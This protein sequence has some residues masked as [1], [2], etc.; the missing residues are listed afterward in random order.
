V[1]PPPGS[2]AP[3]AHESQSNLDDLYAS[4]ADEAGAIEGGGTIIGFGMYKGNPFQFLLTPL[5]TGYGNWLLSPEGRRKTA[6]IP[7]AS[8]LRGWLLAREATSNA[9]PVD[10]GASHQQL[11]LLQDRSPSQRGS[12][13]SGSQ[14][15]SQLGIDCSGSG[16]M[17]LHASIVDVEQ[18]RNTHQPSGGASHPQVSI[19]GSVA[20]PSV[21]GSECVSPTIGVLPTPGNISVSA[22]FGAPPSARPLPPSGPWSPPALEPR[23]GSSGNE[24]ARF[25][26]A[27]SARTVRVP[28]SAGSVEC[29]VGN[30]SMPATWIGSATLRGS[31]APPS[32]T[33]H[34]SVEWGATQGHD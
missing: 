14:A 33:A 18:L 7:Q 29:T 21:A 22:T 8:E 11:S 20:V 30:P 19:V 32:G 34:T 28:E 13:S 31:F 15:C 24:S 3:V 17:A 6:G 1:L 23:R 25:L 9:G 27:A 16:S 10:V 5:A 2:L 12:R 4:Q 26:H